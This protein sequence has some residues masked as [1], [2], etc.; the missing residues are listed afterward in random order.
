MADIISRLKLESGE[1]DSK[2]KRAGQELLAY[3]EHCKKAGLQMGYANKDAKDFAA[4]LGN[5]QTTSTTVRGKISELSEAFI[6][7]RVMY[8]N[9]TDEEKK[10]TFGKNLAASLDQLK[11]RIQSAKADLVEAQSM[12]NGGA[13]GGGGGFLGGKLDGMLQ[14]FG[15][16]L[17]TKG[18]G[19]LAGLGTEMADMVKQGV[20]LAQQGEGIRNA[21]ERLGRGDILDGLREAT[22][23]T[24]TD[25]ELMKAAVKFNDFKLPVEELGTMLAF[26]QQKAK[27][28][29]QSVDYM[30]DSIVTGLGRKSLM[31][32]DNLGLSAAEI[33]EKMAE[34]GDMTKAVGAIIREQMQKAGDYVETA[35][36]RAAKAD[37]DLK[38]AME[39]LGRTFQPLSE[40]GVGAF[41][42][43]KIS[44]LNLLN[45]AVKPLVEM[46]TRA[47]ALR[48]EVEQRGGSER[49]ARDVKWVANSDDKN[50]SYNNL[51]NGYLREE[52]KALNALNEA[53]KGGRGGIGIYEKEYEAAKQLRMEFQESVKPVLEPVDVDINTDK[54]TQSIETLRVKLAE[55]EAQRK[56]AIQAG[57]N[58]LS[59]NLSQ[60]INKIKADIKALDPKALSTSHTATP[61]EKAAEKVSTAQHA[62]DQALEQAA[63]ELKAGTI[64]QAD[65]K[66]KELQAQESLWKSIGD[67]RQIYDAPG[68]KE[69]QDKAADAIVQL[70]G[71]VTKAVEAQKAA[72][73]AARELEQAQ[74]RL[75]VAQDEAAKAASSNDLKSFYQAGKK[76]TANGGKAAAPVGFTATDANIDAFIGNLKERIGQADVGSTL[77]QNLTAQLTDATNLG[78]LLEIAVKNGIDTAQFNPQELWSK[79]FG[80]NPGD[81]ISD[82][83]WK[84]L[85]DNLNKAIK[86]GG[87]KTGYTVDKKTGNITEQ[88][89][90]MKLSDAMSGISGGINS[91]VGGLQQL[92]VEIPK[93]MQDMLGAIQGITTILTAIS[94]IV[95]TIQVISA[96][97]T[98]I[99]FAASGIVHAAGGVRVPG[100]FRSND[101]VPAMLNSGE[102]VLNQAQQGILASELGRSGDQGISMQPYVDGERIFLGMN[103]TSKRMGRG[104]IVTTSM[105]RQRGIL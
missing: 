82:E 49:V 54:A 19:M 60:Q 77:Y 10:N 104:E 100:N 67:A 65:A 33:K 24:V 38:N 41:N 40:A 26:A 103:N 28:T 83:A 39:Q 1:F 32:L 101:M 4:A 52:M 2:I 70:G 34:T 13:A 50:R 5:M 15:G 102:L 3:S 64:T 7:L 20:E 45:T 11:T 98:F 21:F 53:R 14:V 94:T 62:Y 22:H 66:K 81:Y 16:N 95:S 6:N 72:E 58:D 79:I 61:R 93:G 44:A 71:E 30:V 42:D 27:D 69:A 97:D 76:I 37:V 56:K 105:L 96:A 68:Y 31:I 36:D 87:G 47:G 74:K 12:L 89:N 85:L 78:Q 9:M 8:K 80:E 25:I 86:D 73:K 51:L 59:K 75:A 91:M 46:L 48:R 17:M 63:L 29:G 90:T 18:A 92:G 84:S 88:K 57:D 35:A 55:L 43:L 23:G 99:P